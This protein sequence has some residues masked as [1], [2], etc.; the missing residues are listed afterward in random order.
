VPLP[1]EHDMQDGHALISS[2]PDPESASIRRDE[3]RTL[4]GLIADLPDDYREVLILRE[5]EGMG[6]R[7]IAAVT[8]VPLGTVMSRL[9]RARLALK[10]HWLQQVEGEPR[11]V[12]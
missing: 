11:A 5:I 8:K 12:P 4:E 3:E 6:Y 9:A 2:T 1:E 10:K 7:E